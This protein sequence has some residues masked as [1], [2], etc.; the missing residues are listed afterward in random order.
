MVEQ[1]LIFRAARIGDLD[2]LV[3]IENAVFESD[4][5]S[6]RAFAR[7]LASSS[8]A[9]LVV[10]RDAH[11]VGYALVE[12]RRN[13]RCARLFSIAR[14]PEAPAGVGRSLLEACENEAVKRGCTAMRLEAR[15]DNFRALR[16]YESAGYARFAR[17]DGYYE[18]G[19]PALRLEKIFKR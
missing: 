2:G 4:R 5:L 3:A 15:E 8:C 1:A 19:A 13:S 10:E 7:R 18:D 17:V 12:F 14:A 11:L 9:L 16:L 6:R